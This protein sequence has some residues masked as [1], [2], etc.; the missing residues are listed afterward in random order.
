MHVNAWQQHRADCNTLML[1]IKK[2]LKIAIIFKQN[3]I[4]LNWFLHQSTYTR[5]QLMQ[6]FTCIVLLQTYLLLHSMFQ[7]HKVYI[8]NYPTIL[9]CYYSNP[10]GTSTPCRVLYPVDSMNLR[11]K[12]LAQKHPDNYGNGQSNCQLLWCCLHQGLHSHLKV[13]DTE[14]IIKYKV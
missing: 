5:V 1:A 10:Q 6:M 11:G 3:S 8:V 2:W 9:C 14:E 4:W 13:K 12:L 7:A